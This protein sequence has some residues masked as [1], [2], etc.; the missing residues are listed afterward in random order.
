MDRQPFEFQPRLGAHRFPL[1]ESRID[2]RLWQEPIRSI[3]RPLND[4]TAA[5][6]AELRTGRA[7]GLSHYVHIFVGHGLGVGIINDDMP[8]QGFW[9][10]AGEVGLLTWPAELSDPNSSG[11]TLFSIDELAAMS[12]L[13][14]CDLAAPGK[15]EALYSQRDSVLMRWLDLNGR[16]LRLLVSLLENILDPQTIVVGGLSRACVPVLWGRRRRSPALPCCLSL[17]MAALNSGT[18][19]SCADAAKRLI[20]NGG[21]TVL[22]VRPRKMILR[23]EASTQAIWMIS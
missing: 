18:F 23:L 17:H 12:G 15:L 6:V 20:Y 5:T 22:L 1:P 16:R 10:N 4:A 13:E 2:P 8:L 14:S 9:N 7:S 3:F 19:H 21:S 11:Q